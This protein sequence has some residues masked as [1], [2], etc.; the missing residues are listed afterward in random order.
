MVLIFRLEAIEKAQNIEATEEE[1]KE[2][3]SEVAKM[4]SAA[5]DD[6]MIELL[7]QNQ[8]E[9]LKSD[10]ITGKVINFLLENNK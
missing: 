10:V 4:Y 8:K 2:K 1:L 3:A 7:L 6:K 5:E 9:A